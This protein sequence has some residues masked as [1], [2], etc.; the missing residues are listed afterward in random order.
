M[1]IQKEM[2]EIDKQYRRLDR[3]FYTDNA[4][5]EREERLEW[6]RKCREPINNRGDV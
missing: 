6:L 5:K 3:E 1:D 2:I 4:W